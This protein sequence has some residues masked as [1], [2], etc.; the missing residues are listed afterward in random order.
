MGQKE[1]TVFPRIV[2]SLEYFPP[3]NIFRSKNFLMINTA[4]SI[5]IV[6]RG[7][8]HQH[9]AQKMGVRL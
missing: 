7:G 6:P 9:T 2:S 4:Q 8:P 1:Y 5:E 3:L